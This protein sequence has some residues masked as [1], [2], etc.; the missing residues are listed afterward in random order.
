MLAGTCFMVDQADHD[1]KVSHASRAC[2]GK[3]MAISRPEDVASLET[4][5][6]EPAS[7][8]V[9]AGEINRTCPATVDFKSVNTMMTIDHDKT[10]ASI[11]TSITQDAFLPHSVFISDSLD[12]DTYFD[13]KSVGSQP[14]SAV[15][16]AHDAA[17]RDEDRELCL[18][19]RDIERQ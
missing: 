10:L 3:A 9:F 17:R 6:S 2:T 4:C 15:C 8:H 11:P 18:W 19:R 1:C 16:A 13:H 7:H 5:I 12:D 14:P